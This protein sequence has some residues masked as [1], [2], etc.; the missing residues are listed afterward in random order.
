[1]Q[2]AFFKSYNHLNSD[3][4]CRFTILHSYLKKKINFIYDQSRS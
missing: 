2:A 3:C 4:I 1:M